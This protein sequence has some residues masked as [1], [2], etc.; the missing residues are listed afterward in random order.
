MSLRARSG[1]SD[2][3]RDASLDDAALD[4]AQPSTADAQPA[5]WEVLHHSIGNR[6][7]GQLIE[8]QRRAASEGQISVSPE[9]Q[10]QIETERSSGRPLDDD[11]GKDLQSLLGADVA[12]IRLHD[13]AAAA[14]L[15]S[16]LDAN[17]F[18]QG[19]D[20][21]LGSAYQRRTARGDQTLAHEVTHAAMGRTTAGA[22]QREAATATETVVAT[23]A[24]TTAV[25]GTEAVA[26]SAGTETAAVK[27][28]S[29]ST[30]V[31]VPSD[32]EDK[33]SKMADAYYAAKKADIVITDGERT[34]AQQAEYIYRKLDKDGE[35]D[36][37]ALYGNGENIKAIIAAWKTKKTKD[38]QVQAMTE[39]L[40]KQVDAGK[41]ISQHLR[42]NAV[43][44]RSSDG[45]DMA[46]LKK[47]AEANGG[48]LL[49]ESKKK[50][51]PHY[52]IG[53]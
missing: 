53:F 52:H 46:A 25:A 40:D 41:Y 21:F 17:A 51:G 2:N 29:L 44:V 38:E 13:G 37:S 28:Y 7:I 14:A 23:P 8:T 39:A 9:Q 4:L 45:T 33:V 15:A 11:F 12:G 30:D 24:S 10:T 22:V 18:T 31:V 43:D 19:R 6:A 27:H 47:A 34:T 3:R 5:L 36:T 49:D 32:I 16:G 48:S 20:I 1:R 26:A 42:N 35:S 50:A